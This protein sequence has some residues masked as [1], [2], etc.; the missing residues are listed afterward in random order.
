MKNLILGVSTLALSVGFFGLPAVAEDDAV[1]LTAWRL[2]VSDHAAPVVRV[3]DALDG[4]ELDAFTI[5]NPA[6]ALKRSQSGKAVFAVQPNANIVNVISTGITFNDHGDH[7]DIDVDPPT[8]SKAAYSGDFPVHLVEHNAHFSVFFDKEGVVRVF[9]ELDALEGRVETRE[10]S[11]GAPHHGVAVPHG[12]FDLISVPNPDDS[13]ALPIGIKTFDKDGQPVGDLAA[14]PDLHGEA[15]SGNILVF[16]CASGLLVVRDG[17]MDAPEIEHLAY[18]DTLPEGKTTTLVG[19]RGLQYFLGNYGADKVVL[20]DPS[21]ADA[22]RLVQL[23]TRRVHFAVDPIRARFAYVFTEDGQLRQLDAINGELTN[24]IKLTGHYSMDGSWSDPRPRIAVAG[25][26]IIVSD[27]MAGK[28]H[29]VD[30]RSFTETGEVVIEGMPFN[31]VAVGGTGRSHEGEDQD[32][33]GNEEE[34]DHDSERQDHDHDEK[35]TKT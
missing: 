25:D 7:A 21:E 23:P 29:L 27:P 28:L 34:H 2:F 20:I 14:C 30:A 8:M 4:D 11:A 32:D 35:A 1:D 18:A 6:V 26:N 33:H 17:G 10:V 13:D 15:A 5:T 24:S 19:G 3:I 31:V 9:E 22:F 12:N 16:A